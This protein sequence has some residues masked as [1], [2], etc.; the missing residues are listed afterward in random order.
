MKKFKKGQRI[1]SGHR[2]LA[3]FIVIGYKF[4]NYLLVIKEGEE[5][6]LTNR[7]ILYDGHC[8]LAD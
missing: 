5:D 4:D 7:D 3:T 6:K 1:K 2:Y 8:W